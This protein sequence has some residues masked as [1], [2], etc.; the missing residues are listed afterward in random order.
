MQDRIRELE[1]ALARVP[2]TPSGMGHNKPPE[3]MDVEP[4][5]ATDLKEISD[6]LVTL[7][8]QRLE[9]H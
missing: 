5:D 9:P 4:L 2:P 1:E 8:S 6:A 7:G 3:P